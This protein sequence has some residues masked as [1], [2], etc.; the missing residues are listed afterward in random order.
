MLRIFS[1]VTAAFVALLPLQSHAQAQTQLKI[2]TFSA[3]NSPWADGMREF[4][5][6]VK[7]RTQGRINVNVYTD[8][9]LGDM[10]QLLTGMQLGTID[11]AYFDVTVAAF[12]K[13]GETLMIGVSPYLFDSREQAGKVLNSDLFKQVYEDMAAKTGVR[14]FAVYGDRSPRAIQTTKGPIMKPSDLSGMRLRV[15]G[16]DIYKR[17]FETMNV[18]VTPMGM[19]D[20]YN[21]LS[22]GI[23]DGQDN[24]IDVSVPL[25]YHEVAK[26][27]SATDHVYSVTGWFMSEAKWKAMTDADRKIFVDSA[28]DAG[29]VVTKTTEKLE[30]DAKD[31]FKQAGVTYVEPDRA[32]FREALK[33]VYKEFDGKVWPAGMVA[34]IRA[35]QG[36]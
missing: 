35:M 11:M 8:A 20:I 2:G 32:A 29:L 4:S 36:H 26:F 34:K 25:K 1:I 6:L 18:K 7:E 19:T 31:I 14:I 3:A 30:A 17:T 27:W 9:Q 10:Q 15:P 23:V 12:L 13:G 24:G 21:G 16:I 28:K 5:K 33:D 22:R